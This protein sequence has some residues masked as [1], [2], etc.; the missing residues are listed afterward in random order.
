MPRGHLTNML[1]PSPPIYRHPSA[2]P[3][4][5]HAWVPVWDIP[6]GSSWPQR[7]LQYPHA[8]IVVSS[9]YARFYGVATGLSSVELSGRGWA[10]GVALQPSSGRP[11]LGRP[12]A[13]L[14]DSHLGLDRL[15]AL[16]GAELTAAIRGAMA[17]DPHDT[18]AHR[19]CLALVE[20]AVDAVVE[21]DDEADLVDAVC[22]RVETD[23]S[24]TRVSQL[25]EGFGIAE[26]R[27]QRL[28]HDRIGISPKWLIRRRRLQEAAHELRT[29]PDQVLAGLAAD[30]GYADQAHFTRDFSSV[31]GMSPS[32]F[33]RAATTPR[34][35]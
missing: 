21:R 27:L 8:L 30:L 23:P 14:V 17:D 13:E 33:R 34:G 31:V 15:S 20:A 32:G 12:M 22:E 19:S 4:V 6:E 1:A 25:C 28:L 11:L 26:R 5:R 3:A 24:L 10:F 29:H 18:E 35:T 9:S 2:S 16:D 7:T